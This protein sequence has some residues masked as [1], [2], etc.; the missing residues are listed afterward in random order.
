[1]KNRRS[2]LRAITA[3]F[4]VSL[5]PLPATLRADETGVMKEGSLEGQGDHEAA[6]TVA[7]LESGGS[8]YVSFGVDFVLDGAPDPRVALGRDGIDHETLLGKLSSNS[9]TQNY[10]IPEDLDPNNYDEV[11]IWCEQNEMPLARAKM[12]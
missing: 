10:E 8:N 2:V 11:W 9:G 1:M 7:I 12:S 6:G 5:A 4:A 3:G